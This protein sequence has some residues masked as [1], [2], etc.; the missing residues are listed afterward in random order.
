MA[1]EFRL[2]GENLMRSK[3]R[4]IA[5]DSPDEFARAQYQETQ[6][7]TAESRRRT[8]FDT[9]T[10]RGTVQTEGPERQGKHIITSVSAGGPAAPYAVYVHEDLEVE[11]PHGQAKFIE[12]T[13]NESAPFMGA[14]IARRIDLN[15][16]AR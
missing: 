14:R 15:R 16:L 8:P 12:S 4:R 10:L 3:L 5:K 9:G 2:D 6:V 11:H 7:E 13:L 1:S